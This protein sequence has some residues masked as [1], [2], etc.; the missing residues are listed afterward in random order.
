MRRAIGHGTKP[1]DCGSVRHATGAPFVYGPKRPWLFAKVAA[2]SRGWV[3]VRATRSVLIIARPPQKRHGHRRPAIAGMGMRA[4]TLAGAGCV[5]R[6]GYGGPQIVIQGAQRRVGDNIA[7]PRHVIG[8]YGQA[9]GQCLDQH[10][11][12]G[13]GARGFVAQIPS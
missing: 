10:D 11:A 5:Q 4:A 13:I 12:K 6:A 1:E 9:T 8:R 7:R 2:S 3:R